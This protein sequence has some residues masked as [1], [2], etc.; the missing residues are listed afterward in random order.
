V[1]GR[2]LSC[3]SKKRGVGALIAKGR[4]AWP[5]RIK[6]RGQEKKIAKGW[7]RR[8]G[9][10]TRQRASEVQRHGVIRRETRMLRSRILRVWKKLDLMMTGPALREGNLLGLGEKKWTILIGGGGNRLGARGHAG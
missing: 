7:P 1:T 6:G 10:S 5:C 8:F 9:D 3:P 2:E 4:T